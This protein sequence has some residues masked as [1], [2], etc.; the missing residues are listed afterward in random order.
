MVGDGVPSENGMWV[1]DDHEREV[2]WLK[3]LVFLQPSLHDDISEIRLIMQLIPY[4]ALV[5]QPDSTSDDNCCETQADHHR[6][7]GVSMT[8][9]LHLRL[10]DRPVLDE[11]IHSCKQDNY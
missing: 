4:P 5:N 1:R 10:R 2:P 7:P 8:V 11:L 6:H 9:L 3:F